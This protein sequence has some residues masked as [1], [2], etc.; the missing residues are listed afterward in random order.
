MCFLAALCWML[1][2]LAGTVTGFMTSEGRFEQALLA[3]VRWEALGISPEALRAFAQ[4]T[5]RYFR[6]ESDRW[7]PEVS[8]ADGPI[9]ISDAFTQHMAT[10]RDGIRTA[11]TL[12]LAGGALGALL[13]AVAVRKKRFSLAG[14]ELGGLLPLMLAAGLGLWAALDFSSMWGWL[15]RR[16]IPDGIFDA[17]EPVMQLFPGSLF[18][19]YLSPVLT[20]FGLTALCV[21]GLPPLLRAGYRY[22]SQKR[23][24]EC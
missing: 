5:M 15:H 10:V 11:R 20:A 3:Q 16:F 18:A 19:E 14:Y 8:A 9:T 6:G 7:E 12:A 22:F 24:N 13:I 23:S 4:D 21:L 2:G 17:A 1:A